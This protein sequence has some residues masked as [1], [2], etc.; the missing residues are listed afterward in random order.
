MTL[1][2]NKNRALEMQ[3]HNADRNTSTEPQMQNDGGQFWLS[4]ID[5]AKSCPS[6]LA[7]PKMRQAPQR[8]NI[9]TQGLMKV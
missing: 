4:L 9:N 6:A 5:Q 8:R 2:V 1:E 3:I 7:S